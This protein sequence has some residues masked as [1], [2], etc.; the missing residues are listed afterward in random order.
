MLVSITI[1]PENSNC[2][3]SGLATGYDLARFKRPKARAPR[4]IG[5]E[6][7]LEPEGIVSGLPANDPRV[8]Q[9]SSGL[10]RPTG[11][12]AWQPTGAHY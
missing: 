2:T 7:R 8:L 10:L 4:R 6:S 3:Q 11:A 12:P 5:P 1:I 9:R